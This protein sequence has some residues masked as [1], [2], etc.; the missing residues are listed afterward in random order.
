MEHDN[1]ATHWT[2]DNKADDQRFVLEDTICKNSGQKFIIVLALGLD[3]SPLISV[4]FRLPMT[5]QS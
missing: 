1:S 2:N 3:Q 4:P 5:V